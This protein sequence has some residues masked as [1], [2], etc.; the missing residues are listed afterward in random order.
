LHELSFIFLHGLS[1]MRAHHGQVSWSFARVMV[2]EFRQV[3]FA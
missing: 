3:L 1:R 2:A